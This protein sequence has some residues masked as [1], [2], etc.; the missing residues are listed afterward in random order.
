MNSV[1]NSYMTLFGLTAAGGASDARFVIP[2]GSLKKFKN[3]LLNYEL[4]SND[5]FVWFFDDRFANE[6]STDYMNRNIYVQTV[7]NATSTPIVYHRY[8]RAGLYT[9]QLFLKTEKTIITAKLDV[10]VGHNLDQLVLEPATGIY[11]ISKDVDIR[12]SDDSAIIFYTL[13]GTDPRFII[14]RGMWNKAGWLSDS[15]TFNNYST[16]DVVFYNGSQYRFTGL[17]LGIYKNPEPEVDPYYT[18]Y[19]ELNNILKYSAPFNLTADKTIKA[20]AYA[21]KNKIFGIVESQVQ[22]LNVIPEVQILPDPSV[23]YYQPI[24]ISISL[25]NESF[26]NFDVLYSTTGGEPTIKYVSPITIDRTVNFKYVI[27]EKKSQFK[28]PEYL[29]QYTVKNYVSDI[30]VLLNGTDLNLITSS[31]KHSLLL[32]VQSTVYD[33]YQYMFDTDTYS[34]INPLIAPIIIENVIE[35]KHKLYVRGTKSSTGEVQPIPNIYTWNSVFSVNPIEL[36][37]EVPYINPASSIRFEFAPADLLYS[38]RLDNLD[39]SVWESVT[40]PFHLDNIADGVRTLQIYGK[41]FAGNIQ[42]FPTVYTWI[43]DSTK[44]IITINNQSG[45]YTDLV[46]LFVNITDSVSTIDRCKIWYTLDGSDP[47]LTNISTKI[48]DITKG[49]LIPPVSGIYTVKVLARDEAL[50]Y[51]DILTSTFI[52]EMAYPATKT[53]YSLTII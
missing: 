50:N 42:E 46:Q 9:V 47:A 48:Y 27:V 10:Q 21:S 37:T 30:Q 1:S 19:W 6:D 20:I 12:C 31:N 45:T 5:I 3:E 43:K 15:Q 14:N 8:S 28:S 35:G 18:K 52:I 38:Y 32:N 7:G 16:D 53:L 39:W 24:E 2:N 40:V 26:D 29:I 23:T 44:P 25:I 41:D 17:F 4:S 49:I 33:Q 13:D 36:L 34:A 22:F 11:N 51:S